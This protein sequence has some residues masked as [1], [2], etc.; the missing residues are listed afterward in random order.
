LKKRLLPLLLLA[1]LPAQAATFT[2]TK[3]ADTLDGACDRDCSLREAVAAANADDPL[4]G[5][6]VV[7]VPPGIYVLTRTGAGEDAGAT[8]DLDLN[9]Q[10]ILV[11]AG[12][13]HTVIDGHGFD[14]VLDARAPAEI[15]GVTIRNGRVDGDGGGLLV[16]FNPAPQPVLLRRSVVSG[17]QAQAGADGGGIAAFGPLEVR[18]SALL[19]NHAEGDGGGIAGTVEISL[20][21][22]TV[23]DNRAEGSGGGVKDVFLWNSTVVFNQAEVSGGGGFWTS[24]PDPIPATNDRFYGS[25]VSDNF[26]P[27]GRDCA[28]DVS[29]GGYSVIGVADGCSPGPTDKAGT[30][31]HRLSAVF[32]V[33][34]TRLG[35]TPV[36]VPFLNSPA[37]AM[38]PAG[39]CEP[40]DQLGQARSAPCDA[41]ALEQVDHP[42][43]L[44]GGSVLCLQEG[45][46]RVSAALIER[47][48]SRG[49]QAVPLTDDTGNYWFFAPDNLEIMVKVLNGC[50][51][52]GHWWLF[53]SGLTDVG[54]HLEA[55]D[56]GTGRTRVIE[57]E[58]GTTFPPRLNTTA[59][60]CEPAA[61]NANGASAPPGAGIL[62]EEVFRV[63]K[64]A[65]TDDGRCDHDCS[66]REAVVAANS[67]PTTS[68]ILLEPGVYT[69]TRAGREEEEAHAGDLDV[70]EPLVILGAGA[71]RTI[72][73]G[74]QLDRVLDVR[75]SFAVS[76][77]LYDLT[78]RNGSAVTDPTA[79]H[80]GGGGI[81][82]VQGALT[83]V[84][85]A[86]TGNRS[87]SWAGGVL[88]FGPFTMRDSTVS[89]N[90]SGFLGGGLATGEFTDMENVTVSGNHADLHGGGILLG[91]DDIRLESVTVTGNSAL[92]G[93]GIAMSPPTCPGFPCTGPVRIDRTVV[94]G[95]TVPPDGIGP[96]FFDMVPFSGEHNVFE[97]DPKL[98]PLGDHGGPTLTHLPLPGS[99]ALDAATGCLPA[100][101]RGL[102]RPASG[103]DVGAVEVQ[104]SCETDTE[105]LCLGAGS[106]FR[107]TA[108]WTA[109]GNDGPGK[110]VP[111]ALDTG[112]FWF[113]D[114]AN[115]EL[116]VK[117]LDGCGVNN[118][119]WVFLSGLTDVGVEVTVEDTAT[120]ET[121]THT[122]APGTAL[123]PRLDTSALEVCPQ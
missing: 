59:F 96:D 106:R 90:T 123:E 111:L 54:V 117:V 22:S 108:H 8:G 119:F 21:N 79:T 120:G 91:T 81:E 26:A 42:A 113:F 17:N 34:D 65:D 37:L 44:P 46:F 84:R 3:T 98:S 31:E 60:P 11:G 86:V 95:N 102:A 116:T 70:R 16:R 100:D 48:P 64:A 88:A 66:L 114:A 25:I 72:L 104:R 27:A 97:V 12:A 109:Q 92:R 68:V 105:T 41:G 23:S 82:S 49:A 18:D 118:R 107:V 40:A 121:W 14:R 75:P 76:L 83:L 67:R 13:G 71:K 50:A 39:F 1:A 99:P 10:M 62:H 47:F 112:A 19:E 52:N 5:A 36:H 89:G 77:E 6:D 7:V 74:N 58:G 55:V 30:A 57:H 115:L 53:A 94:A 15:Y 73:D 78:V 80:Q 85:V 87:S 43:C 2:V 103:C 38:V 122:H 24:D 51:V 56:L 61:G 9:D 32:R 110:S 63:T 29:S 69:L 28:G 33:Q 35:P 4:G 93:G 101:Q 20:F 45:R